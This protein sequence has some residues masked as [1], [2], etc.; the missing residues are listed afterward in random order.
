MSKMS[1][2]RY[3]YFN[4][5]DREPTTEVA[6]IGALW[7]DTSEDELYIKAPTEWRLIKTK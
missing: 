5:Y 3:T 2:G 6:P 7:Y 4:I 1:D